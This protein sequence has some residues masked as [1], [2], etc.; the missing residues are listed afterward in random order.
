MR[1]VKPSQMHEAVGEYSASNAKKTK[2]AINEKNQRVA[3]A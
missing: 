3:A 1:K 2:K